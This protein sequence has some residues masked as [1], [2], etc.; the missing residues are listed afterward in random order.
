M[1]GWVSVDSEAWGWVVC[2]GRV[3]GCCVCIVDVINV[4]GW[5][6][7]LLILQGMIL[8]QVA[9]IVVLAWN[10]RPSSLVLVVELIGG[11]ESW[12][13]WRT[14]RGGILW[15]RISRRIA[16][17][18]V[19]SIGMAWKILIVG[20]IGSV[21]RPWILGGARRDICVVDSG[22]VWVLLEVVGFL[23][24]RVQNA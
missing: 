14:G 21:Q 17:I 15:V 4:D 24:M 2:V 1:I 18:D 13:S 8:N 5:V 19:W 6:D 9:I 16:L 3:D 20:A 23:G 7:A 11:W 12:S 10:V 22:N